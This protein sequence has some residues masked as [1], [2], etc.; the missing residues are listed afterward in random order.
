MRS[1]SLPK[2]V[3]L[4][5]LGLATACS[6]V[7]QVKVQ[8]TD[9]LKVQEQIIK[10]FGHKNIGTRVQNGSVLT[11]EAV[12][13]PWKGLAGAEKRDKAAAIAKVAY[14]S[15]ASRANLQTVHVAFVT[16]TSYL[17]IVHLRD[18]SDA[19]TFGSAEL[20]FIASPTL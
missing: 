19:F 2:L 17:G 18:A 8:F 20:V 13:S 4:A 7:Q 6:G 16:Y 1:C 14:D 15:Y 5:V 12:N 10:V 11:V 3:L 9:Q